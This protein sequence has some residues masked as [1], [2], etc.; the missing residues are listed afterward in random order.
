MTQLSFTRKIIV[1]VGALLVLSVLLAI[2]LQAFIS[3]S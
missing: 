3:A 2:V 1:V